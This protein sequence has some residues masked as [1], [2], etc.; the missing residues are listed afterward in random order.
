VINLTRKRSKKVK[1]KSTPKQSKKIVTKP[2][3]ISRKKKVIIPIILIGL[4]CVVLF[5]NSYFNYNAGTAFN[6]EGDTIGTRFYLSGP[7]PYYNMRSCQESLESGYYRF[8]T[9]EDPLLNYP[10]GH[11][12]SSRPPLFNSIAMGSTLVLENFMPRIDALGWSMLFLPAIYGALL[13]FP[14]YGLGKEIFNKKAG[15]I[16]ALFVPLIP[17][18]IGAGHGSAFSLFDHDSFVL[19]LATIVFYFTVKSIKEENFNK[20]IFYAILAG[21]GIGSLELTWIAS[22]VVYIMLAVYLV[23]Q[24]FFNILQTKHEMK[25]FYTIVVALTVGFLIS[26]PYVMAKQ[27]VFTYLFFTLTISIALLFIQGIIKKL[28]FPWLI[29]LPG[30]CFLTAGGF[31]ILFYINRVIGKTAGALYS[32]STVIFGEGIYGS[33]VSQ[34]IGEAHTF[35]ISQTVMSFG[36]IFYW[37][38]LFGFVL[39]LLKTFKEK[40]T[41]QNLFVIVVFLM[42]FWLTTTAGRF[43]NDLIPLFCI[44]TGFII[45]RII[46]KINYQL[47]IR[48][49]K[50]VGGF[51]GIYKATKIKHIFGIVFVFFLITPN[52]FL[53]LDA[54]VPPEMK[55]DIFG[56]DYSGYFGN[57]LAYQVFW[58]DA[59]DWLHD[60]DT[61]IKNPANRPGVI[62]WWDYGFYIAS[63]SEHPTVADNFQEGLRCAAN[64]HTAETEKEATA[65]LII[66]IAESEK[67]PKRIAIGTLSNRAKELFRQHLG[68]DSELFIDIMENP[69]K[70]APSYNTLVSEEYG[71]KNV[72]VDEFNAMYHDGCNIITNLTDYEVTKLYHDIINLTGKE[73]RYYAIDSRDL[74]EIFGVFP[75]LS[76]KGTHGFQTIEDRYFITYYIDKKTGNLYTENQ[77]NN[78]SKSDLEDM[79]LGS[80]VQ[81]KDDYFDTFIY[82]C[83]YGIHNNKEIPE[84]RIPTYLLKHWKVEYVSPVVTI[85]KFY[86]G[87]TI[88]GNVQNFTKYNQSYVAIYGENGVAH[89]TRYVWI[90]GTF[91]VTGLKGNNTIKLFEGQNNTFTGFE[92]TVYI[93][94]EEATWEV[95]CNKEVLIEVK[96]EL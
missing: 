65:V 4:F 96:D 91:Q 57:S 87:A 78:L 77:I 19:L 79:D 10:L 13:V 20:R 30:I 59:C 61:E 42:Y 83:Y 27:N 58:S 2:K 15:L 93:S 71:N 86:E 12:G 14:V 43:L 53:A 72:R 90:D 55:Q 64:F 24:L 22:Q 92:T 28:N 94:E 95:E 25:N 70:N 40:F 6:E 88:K 67:N 23:I 1:Y 63:M 41:S 80:T 50:S 85:V 62:S 29:T 60:Q 69:E 17:I 37:V 26:L 82:R 84:E 76:D 47:L 16:G 5:F 35:G 48:N 31:G 38:G 34:T 32:I 36:P 51:R 44:F 81:R 33:Q 52:T 39:F 75:Y 73:I 54:A 7:D 89:D 45:W 68:N 11:Y 3:I 8:V 9:E 46:E 56:D 18:H 66:R 49:I 74:V 21:V